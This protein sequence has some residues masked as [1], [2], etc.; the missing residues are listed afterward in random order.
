MVISMIH[1]P[2]NLDIVLPLENELITASTITLQQIL[3]NLLTNA[4]RYNDKEKGIIQI[5]FKQDEANFYFE[6]EDNG[7]GIAKQYYEQIFAANFTLKITDRYD[8]KGT[9]IGLSTVKELTRAVNGKIRIWSELK[10]FTIFY[11]AI[12]K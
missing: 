11:I 8:K 9:G 6:V 3:S 2:E 5:R 10:K 4:I 1:V 7:I 12:P